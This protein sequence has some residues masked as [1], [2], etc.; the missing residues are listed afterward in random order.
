MPKATP[1]AASAGWSASR[2]RRNRAGKRDSVGYWLHAAKKEINAGGAS[3]EDDTDAQRI[4][5]SVGVRAV[6]DDTYPNLTLPAEKRPWFIAVS[7]SHEGTGSV[8]AGS[9]WQMRPG[10]QGVWVQS[11]R[12]LAG[13]QPG[14]M[15]IDGRTCRCTLLPWGR[16]VTRRA[17]ARRRRRRRT[18]T[19]N[20]ART[21]DPA[22]TIEE[23]A[24]TH[25]IGGGQ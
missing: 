16:G 25:A 22:R 19:M 5:A 18:A 20:R 9:H 4:L 11:L 21:A 7:N 23:V 8:F 15:W 1:S 3:A 17:T 10:T 12:R 13:A 24:M 6:R 14:R 2:A